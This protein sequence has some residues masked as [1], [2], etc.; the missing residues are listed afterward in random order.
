MKKNDPVGYGGHLYIP[1][2]QELEQMF[3]EENSP[4]GLKKRLN[5]KYGRKNDG[6]DEKNHHGGS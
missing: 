2:Y 4:E 5:N 1:T 6:C 3:D